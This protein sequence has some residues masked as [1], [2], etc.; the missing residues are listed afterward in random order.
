MRPDETGM[1]RDASIIPSAHKLYRGIP[2]SNFR[3]PLIA[4]IR[5]PYRVVTN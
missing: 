3:V 2:D 1:A 4:E 5:I